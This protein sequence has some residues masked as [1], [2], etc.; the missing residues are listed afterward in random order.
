MLFIDLRNI[1]E[2]GD[3][4]GEWLFKYML[5]FTLMALWPIT[6]PLLIIVSII[7]RVF[8][9]ERYNPGYHDKT[10]RLGER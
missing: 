4:V 7:W 10:F 3:T 1:T 6:S 5:T 2:L 9:S 8:N